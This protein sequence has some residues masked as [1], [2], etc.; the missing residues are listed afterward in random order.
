MD[1]KVFIKALSFSAVLVFLPIGALVLL[2]SHRARDGYWIS[3]KMLIKYEAGADSELFLRILEAAEDHR[4]RDH[5][6]IDPIG[7]VRAMCN[8]LRGRHLEGASTIEQQYVRTCTGNRKI[9]LVRKLE[10]VTAS[11]LLALFSNKNDIAYSYICCAYFGEGLRG[12]KSV[13]SALW[14]VKHESA[15]ET[16][17]AAAVIAMLKRPRPIGCSV[18]WE[19]AL[20]NRADYIVNRHFEVC[21]NHSLQARYL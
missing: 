14:L 9:S 5:W 12:Y 8:L 21:A 18:K 17:R 3:R 11:V 7:I 10:E 2:L 4:Y 6:G 1:K 16:Y 20:Q 15:T 13:V 19:I